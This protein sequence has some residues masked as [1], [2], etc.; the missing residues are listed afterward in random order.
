M[1]AVLL[2]FCFVFA[3]LY[4]RFASDFYVSHRCE[5]S[6]KIASFRF[7]FASFRFEAKMTAHP[8]NVYPTSHS[9]ILMQTLHKKMLL[10]SVADP[11]PFDTDPNL[12]VHFDTDPDPA[13]QS[14]VDPDPAVLSGSDPDSCR[15]KEVMYLKQVLFI[16]LT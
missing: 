3:L 5:T 9:G 6:K 1:M 7:R 2:L 8:N 15:L 4:F 10:S 11:I 12:A 16:H 13:F 14:D